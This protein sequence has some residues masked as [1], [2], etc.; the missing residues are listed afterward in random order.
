VTKFGRYIAEAK[1]A[2]LKARVASHL[3]GKP[4]ARRRP[5][6]EGGQGTMME[7][8]PVAKIKREAEVNSTA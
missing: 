5:R 7:K 8:Q 6:S 3:L 2:H 1:A 4:Y